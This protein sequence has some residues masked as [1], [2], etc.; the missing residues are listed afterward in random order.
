[1][2]KSGDIMGGMRVKTSVKLLESQAHKIYA[3]TLLR[4][5]SDTRFV[6][7]NYLDWIQWHF[8]RFFFFF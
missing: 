6:E 5:I 2:M 4:D 1:M 7:K 3:F 8:S